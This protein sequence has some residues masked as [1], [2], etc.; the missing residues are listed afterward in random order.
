M[1]APTPDQEKEL[2]ARW[3]S[4]ALAWHFQRPEEA[5][6]LH[7]AVLNIYNDKPVDSLIYVQDTGAASLH[8]NRTPGNGLIVA[9]GPNPD[10]ETY[11]VTLRPGAGSWT[12]LGVDV[13]EDESLPGN[14][15]S[16]G[17]DRFLLTG[18][19]AVLQEAGQPARKLD[20]LHRTGR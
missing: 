13:V 18:V 10:N 6:S 4:G 5:H 15:I 7:G 3:K 19:E 1:P 17:A 8:P 20:V 12:E 11:V 16:R 2:T 9:S 14:R